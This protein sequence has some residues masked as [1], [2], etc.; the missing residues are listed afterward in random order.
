M[1]VDAKPHQKLARSRRGEV[2]FV[3][4]HSATWVGGEKQGG[5]RK[6]NVAAPIDCLSMHHGIW[7]IQIS[8]AFR[9]MFLCLGIKVFRCLLFRIHIQVE[10]GHWS[11]EPP[12]LRLRKQYLHP[13]RQSRQ[14]KWLRMTEFVC[15][16]TDVI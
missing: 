8:R 16:P 12:T 3:L 2:P 10:L 5:E 4:L 7:C 13:P 14:L 11:G 15:R 1:I 6:K 9:L